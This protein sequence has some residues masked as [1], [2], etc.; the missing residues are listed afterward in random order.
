MDVLLSVVAILVFCHLGPPS[1]ITPVIICSLLALVPSDMLPV[2]TK[3][4]ACSSLM[5][6]LTCQQSHLQQTQW[7]QAPFDT[8]RKFSPRRVGPW[9]RNRPHA[10]QPRSVVCKRFCWL[11]PRL[12]SVLVEVKKLFRRLTL[13]NFSPHHTRS[14]PTRS[15]RDQIDT[16][17]DSVRKASYSSLNNTCDLN[18]TRAGSILI[19]W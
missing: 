13:A 3:H 12:G 14:D 6:K 10:L 7:H 16:C 2:N 9:L 8:P 17:T 5:S 4:F 15:I 19:R 11:L 18:P 1:L